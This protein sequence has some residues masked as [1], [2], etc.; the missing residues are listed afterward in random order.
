M[1]LGCVAAAMSL[2]FAPLS[3][4][5]ADWPGFRGPQGSA[6]SAD[7]DVP[8]SWAK[9]NMLWKIK[10]PGLGASSPITYGDK[11]FV[12]CYSGYGTTLSKGMGKGGF[13]KGGPPKG[14]F[15]KGEPDT[16]DQKKLRLH[17][18]C[19]DSKKGSVV[20][21]KEI[22]PKLPEAAFTG[23]MREHG[24]A[25][26]TPITDGERIYVFFGKSGVFAFDMAGKQLW[27]ADV[28]SRTDK[29]GSA[30][31]PIL[32]KNLVIINAAIESGSLIGL[33]KATGKE[34][35]RTKGI[36]TSW[37]SPLLVESRDG[38]AEIVL[39]LFGKIVG[40]EPDGGKELWYCQG[41]G[42]GGGG[43]FGGFGY[44]CSTPVAKD[45][46]VYVIGG[47][48]PSGPATALAV[49]T[50]GKGDVTKTH[51]LWRAKAGA[52]I[53]SPVVVGHHLCWV[54]GN[55]VCLKLDTGEVVYNE[56]VYDGRQEYVS[57]VAAG[58]KI[59]AL[60]RFDGLYVLA[61]GAKFE[62]LAHNEFAGDKS[63]FNASPAL[64]DGRLYVRSN[65]FLYCVGK[66]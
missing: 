61:A 63:I 23:F 47:G 15:G 27:R 46:V 66:R 59:L 26:S 50:G 10:L 58:D 49:K 24:Y 39:S 11:I 9:E 29:W 55:A 12:T 51:V 53:A 20:W 40:Y 56:R 48:G 8:V 33:D 65:E 42:G 34:V 7:S 32:Y 30:A 17:L 43:G 1:K 35:W 25:S 13:G 57:A 5:A 60:T 64:A 41:I 22:E 18:V 38:K 3:A 36:S 44:T 14:G 4:G 37:A 21:Q 6:V 62:K 54:A 28:G 52:S 16:G 2:V 31:S 45:G 19:L